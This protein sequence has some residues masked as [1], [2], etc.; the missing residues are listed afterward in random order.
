M[1]EPGAREPPPAPTAAPA[2]RRGAGATRAALLVLLALGTIWAGCVSTERSWGWDESMHA[3]LPAARVLLALREG[4]PEVALR[5]VLECQQY[6]FAYP[7]VLAA[8]QSVTGL[9]E[10]ACRMAGRVVWA[11]GCLGIFLAARA[12]SRAA[13][14]R[15]GAELVPWLALALAAASPLALAYSGTL[16]LEVP[17]VAVAAWTLRAWLR[18]GTAARDLAAG[19]WWTAA[20]F[21]K[22]NYGLLLGLGLALD[23]ACE[24]I[25]ATRRGAGGAWARR[26][27][28]L[29]AAPAVALVWWLVLPLPGGLEVGEQHRAALAAFLTGNLGHGRTPFG[30]RAIDWSVALAGT[31]RALVLVLLGCGL[32][33][34]DVRRPATR[35]LVLVALAGAVPIALHDFHLDRFLLMPALGLWLTAAVG[36]SRALPS[37]RAG[38]AWALGLVALAALAPG[39]DGAWVARAAGVLPPEGPRREY[40]LDLL[41]EKRSLHPGRVLP[42]AGLERAEAD[43]L[44]DLIDGAVEPGEE[45]GWIG[46]S[47][48]M[49]PAALWIG[50]YL[51]QSSSEERRAAGRRLLA[52]EPR[53]IY[54]TFEGVDPGWSD[55]R[56]LDFAARFDAVLATD[57]PDLK[58]RAGRAFAGAYRERLLAD[59][60]WSAQEVGTI[61]VSRPLGAPLDVRVLVCRPRP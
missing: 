41:A 17:F 11:L 50:L 45:L 14:G 47:S 55:A 12:W 21:T 2:P 30:P 52:R 51:R 1:S 18:R 60:G 42:T 22:F 43:R 19:A 38:R 36:W 25:A 23:L 58:G 20:F 6:P 27:P 57:P 3:E 28:V 56:L 32:A 9:S 5:T 15:R 33:L 29:A 44:L 24:G 35:A 49:S 59:P 7:L 26:L 37:G 46:V 53:P 40:V 61:A 16:F 48:E 31:P 13:A 10:T 54:V 39:P 4:A 8:V 34:A